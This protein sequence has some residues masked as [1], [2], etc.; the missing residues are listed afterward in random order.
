MAVYDIAVGATSNVSAILNSTKV[1]V[2]STVSCYYATG[3]NPVAYAGNCAILPAGVVR[4][5]NCGPGNL[6]ASGGNITQA[7]QGPQIAF[8]A[9]SG[10]GTV[11]V[12]EIGWVNFAVTPW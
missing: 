2:S 1:K 11:S 5:I 12:T 4:D 6:I 8:L 10:T 7:G 3:H 9:V